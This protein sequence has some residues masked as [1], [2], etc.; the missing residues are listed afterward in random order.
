MCQRS[1]RLSLIISALLHL[2]FAALFSSDFLCLAQ[3]AGFLPRQN[4]FY[5]IFAN[6]RHG[7]LL[8]YLQA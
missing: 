6:N 4:G 5:F 1:V 2:F 8:Q 3:G 7:L